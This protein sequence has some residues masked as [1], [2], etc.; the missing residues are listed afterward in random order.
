MLVAEVVLLGVALR[1]LPALTSSCRSA[2]QQLTE[3][4]R[5][6]QTEERMVA[7]AADLTGAGARLDQWLVASGTYGLDSAGLNRLP[8]ELAA[9]VGLAGLELLRFDRGEVE[10]LTA[11]RKEIGNRVACSLDLR[12]DYPALVRFLWLQESRLPALNLARLRV[13]RPGG[14]VQGLSISIAFS[15]PMF[16]VLGSAGTGGG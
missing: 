11:G 10:A 7:Q 6:K 5:E 4:R 8:Q 9:V 16:S 2:R 15:A 14:A 3:R 12:G 1:V 13:V